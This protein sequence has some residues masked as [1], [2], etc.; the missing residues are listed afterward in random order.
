MRGG[1]GE[2]EY[3][4]GAFG[5][6]FYKRQSRE[7][8]KKRSNISGMISKEKVKVFLLAVLKR[9]LAGQYLWIRGFS[10]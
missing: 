1:T 7:S 6:E 4:E 5:S 3:V 8:W 10:L 9:V 2:E